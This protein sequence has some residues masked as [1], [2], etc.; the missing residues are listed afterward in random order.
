MIVDPSI[1][2]LDKYPQSSAAELDDPSLC[3]IRL[4]KERSK[5]KFLLE[6]PFPDGLFEALTETSEK[7][8]APPITLALSVPR[9]KREEE[10]F[11]ED[12]E[13]LFCAALYGDLSVMIKDFFTDADISYAFSL[14]HSVFCRLQQEGREFNGYVKKG[15]LISSPAFLLRRAKLHH[16]D[17]ICF[18]LDTLLC[19]IFGCSPE[20]LARSVDA[21][22]ELREIWRRYLESAAPDCAFAL[23]CRELCD[24]ELLHDFISFARIRDVYI[25]KN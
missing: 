6:A 9:S 19:R 14:M 25:D 15:L 21:K 4:Q 1:D 11:C 22:N 13:A 8:G 2:T 23:K 3:R 16:P 20:R 24:S 18:E 12:A 7:L 10:R 17:F 5:N